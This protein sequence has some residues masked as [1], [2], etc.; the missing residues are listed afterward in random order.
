MK[1]QQVEKLETSFD[2]KEIEFLNNLLRENFALS[3]TF[4]KL[5]LL[6][7]IFVTCSYE[8]IF[9][10]DE[11][12]SLDDVFNRT[13]QVLKKIPNHQNVLFNEL[14]QSFNNLNFNNN[15]A[16]LNSSIKLTFN[17]LLFNLQ[18]VIRSKN[19]HNFDLLGSFFNIF[20]S[21]NDVSLGQVFT[22]LHIIDFMYD[23]IECNFNDNILDAT[24]G[25]GGFLVRS[26]YNGLAQSGGLVSNNENHLNGIEIDQSAYLL[27]VAN[28]F[29]HNTEQINILHADCNSELAK[30]W[31]KSK[32]INRVLMNPPYERKLKPLEIV[33]NVLDNVETDCVCAFL[34]PNDK[35]TTYKKEVYTL[36]INHT[37]KTIIKLP[38]N[39]FQVAT[40]DISVFIFIAH[41]PQNKKRIFTCAMVQD[42]LK[43][44]KNNK[45]VDVLNQWDYWKKYWVQVVKENSD[46]IFDTGI[47]IQDNQ[48]LTYSVLKNKQQDEISFLKNID[49]NKQAITNKIIEYLLNKQNANEIIDYNK[50]KNWYVQISK[51]LKQNITLNEGIEIDFSR[52]KYFDLIKDKNNNGIFLL[53]SDAG[54]SISS[55]K[56]KNQD[57]EN[58]S[59]KKQNNNYSY[60]TRTDYN[61]AKALFIT[62][63]EKT[64][65]YTNVP[66]FSIGTDTAT[67]HYQTDPFYSGGSIRLLRNENINKQDASVI[68]FLESII[69]CVLKSSFS[70]GGNG[71]SS[72]RLKNVKIPLPVKNKELDFEYMKEIV[73][74]ICKV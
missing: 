45:H 54:F 10:K 69:D 27:A 19:I 8:P 13:K 21:Y 42:G 2:V 44:F 48:P 28:S 29:L 34:L 1:K 39:L 61:N 53:E 72:N 51:L 55:N 9:K 33:K 20:N 7:G 6:V 40:G 11:M 30:E 64:K 74:S 23:A 65:L 71:A 50:T 73:N 14:V 38:S 70:W 37:L 3:N 5:L 59:L 25:S 15:V 12:V 60:I 56:F 31:I 36:L 52:F 16:I 35:L 22:P 41:R 43:S 68:I 49:F 47:W 24:C 46:P 66:I 67:I 26:L 18:N 58:V 17:N 32:K 63:Q 4:D 62:K 57:K